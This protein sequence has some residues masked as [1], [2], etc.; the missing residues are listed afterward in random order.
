M[1]RIS[2][3]SLLALAGLIVILVFSLGI[4]VGATIHA[5]ITKQLSADRAA[6]VETER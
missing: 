2:D 1:K 5:G 3:D 6:V 4:I